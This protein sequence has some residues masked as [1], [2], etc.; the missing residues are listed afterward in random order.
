MTLQLQLLKGWAST[1]CWALLERLG[2][3]RQGKEPGVP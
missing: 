3:R 1:E 2:R